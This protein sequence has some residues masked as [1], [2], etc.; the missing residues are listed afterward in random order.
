MIG[1][2]HNIKGKRINDR[3]LILDELFKRYEFDSVLDIGCGKGDLFNN[4]NERGIKYT[5]TGVDLMSKELVEV[6]TFKYIEADFNNWLTEEK[7][8][9]IFTS[10]VIEHNPNTE[11]FLQNFFSFAKE[12][13]TF[14]LIWPK[15][16]PRIVG[17]HVHTFNMGLMLY[18]IIRTGID[19]SK[20]EMYQAGY[21]L[22]I[23]G[24]VKRFELP[25]LT[26]NKHEIETFKS[27]FPF[28]AIQ[29][30]DGDSPSGF[31]KLR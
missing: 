23:L 18:N 9:L 25:E 12:G 10:H 14:C 1:T 7:F 15:P 28:P 22:C 13:G 19:C 8:D 20:V 21:N 27:K 26:Y 16:K 2:T 17:G 11:L 24:T 3:G 5:G 31:K 30:F 6:D 29:G 4:L